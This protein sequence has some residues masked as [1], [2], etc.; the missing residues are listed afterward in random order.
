M[1]KGGA[2]R[3]L[4]ILRVQTQKNMFESLLTV[5]SALRW[6]TLLLLLTAI[7]Q[8]FAGWM[9]NK[10]YTPGNRK[11]SLFTVITVHTQLVL[12]LVLYFMSPWT[13]TGMA[14][15]GAAMKDTVLRFWTVEH[16]SMMVVAIVLITIG[17]VSAKKASADISK[18]KRTFW[19]FFIA[20]L[21]ILASIPWPFMQTGEGRGWF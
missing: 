15:M 19:Y 11:I 20:L 17:S 1:I 13:K 8:S 12:G 6:V 16:I 3:F 7:A 2:K 14:D 9:G 21:L 18:H 5:H 10:A 4:L